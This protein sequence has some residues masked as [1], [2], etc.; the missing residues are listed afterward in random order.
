MRGSATRCPTR[1]CCRPPPKRQRKSLETVGE[2][3]YWPLFYPT[4]NRAYLVISTR[5]NS[6]SSLVLRNLL[7]E[8]PGTGMVLSFIP[9]L[10]EHPSIPNFVQTILEGEHVKKGA[11]FSCSAIIS[12][13]FRNLW[14]AGPVSHLTS[15]RRRPTWKAAAAALRSWP[16]W[17][18]CCC[19][20]LLLGVSPS[21]NAHQLEFLSLKPKESRFLNV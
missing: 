19:L 20:L 15:N 8:Y 3:I 10:H 17:R 18:R 6:R 21:P 13:S 2:F 14:A 5:N 7:P 16:S 11:Y 1:S 9:V 12:E 4:Q